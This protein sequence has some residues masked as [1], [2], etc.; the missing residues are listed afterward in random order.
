MFDNRT[1]PQFRRPCGL[2]S[3][4][5]ATEIPLTGISPVLSLP[6]LVKAPHDRVHFPQDAQ[7]NSPPVLTRARLLRRPNVSSPNEQQ[8][9]RQ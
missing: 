8:Q 7:C 9:S 1:K 2:A 6:L 5:Y 3:A 4:D